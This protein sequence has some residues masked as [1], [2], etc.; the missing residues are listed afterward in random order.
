M[1]TE[2]LLVEAQLNKLKIKSDVNMSENIYQPWKNKLFFKNVREY[3]KV[4]IFTL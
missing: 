1:D 2:V 4:T 3:R